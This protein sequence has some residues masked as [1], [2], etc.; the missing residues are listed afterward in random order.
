MARL[1]RVVGAGIGSSAGDHLEEGMGDR[2]VVVGMGDR[3]DRRVPGGREGREV[4]LLRQ[5]V[6]CGIFVSY[7]SFARRMTMGLRG[8]FWEKR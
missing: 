4:G 1:H 3:L 8:K 7:V 2:L 6:L 5:R